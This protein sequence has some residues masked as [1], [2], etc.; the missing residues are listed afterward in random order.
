MLPYDAFV[1]EFRVHYA[2]FFDPGFGSVEADG[3]GSRAVLEVRS[4]EV[5]FLIEHG[6]VV[7]RMLYEPLIARPDRLYGGAIGSSYQRQGLALSKHFEEGS[8]EI[9][10]C[11]Q[12]LARRGGRCRPRDGAGQGIAALDAVVSARDRRRTPVARAGE[13]ERTAQRDGRDNRIAR[14]MR[15]DGHRLLSRPGLPRR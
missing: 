3:S 11:P 14:D 2:G 6:Q 10:P 13:A 8:V 5:P 7:G 4:R 15:T 9:G 12:R 1:G